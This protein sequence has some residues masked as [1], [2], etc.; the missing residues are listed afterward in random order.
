M[1]LT[2]KFTDREILGIQNTLISLAKEKLTKKQKSVI[3]LLSILN[4]NNS[5]ATK[6]VDNISLK[7]NCSKSTI[8]NIMRSLKKLGIINCGSKESKGEIVVLTETGK[9]INAEVNRNEF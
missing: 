6:I 2:N 5:N 3:L 8:W 1:S 9:I 4:I 7:L